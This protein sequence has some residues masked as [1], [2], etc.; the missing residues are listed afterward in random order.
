MITGQYNWDYRF[1]E[2]AEHVATW[3]K[4]PSRK[5]GAVIV[6]DKRRI[7]SVG[8]NGFPAGLEDTDT[9]LL[10]RDT[11]Y[12]FM[13][14]AERNAIENASVASFEGCTLYS[15]LLPCIECA[16]SIVSKEIRRVVTYKVDNDPRNEVLLHDYTATLFN[17]V[18]VEVLFYDKRYK[19]NHLHHQCSC[20]VSSNGV[21]QPCVPAWK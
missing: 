12:K 14:H 17:E 10:D 13:Q 19:Q 7:V 16:K 3:S 15:T 11:K 9:R 4:D 1:L 8:Y 2:L 21:Q 5:V 18:G 20:G 6:N